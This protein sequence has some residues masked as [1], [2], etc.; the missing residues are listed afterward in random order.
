MGQVTNCLAVYV[1]GLLP[2]QPRRII[3]L[4]DISQ[5]TNIVRLFSMLKKD[6]PES[7]VCYYQESIRP[8]TVS[9]ALNPTKRLTQA[10]VGTYIKPGAASPFLRSYIKFFDRAL[11]LYINE[12]VLDGYR[13]L[14]QHYQKDDRICLFGCVLVFLGGR[15]IIQSDI[16]P[17]GYSRGAY[18]ARALAG[19]LHKVR[20]SLSSFNTTYQDCRWACYPRETTS[21]SRSR[22]R[23]TSAEI[24]ILRSWRLVS[25]RSFV[26]K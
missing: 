8:S 7:Q 17:E 12:H 22:T 6:D 26:A 18:I 16:F 24:T 21:K 15:H 2:H 5:N 1:I 19:M 3:D 10:G 25:K 4:V 13:F 14:M 11:A 20:P 9:Y 23:Y